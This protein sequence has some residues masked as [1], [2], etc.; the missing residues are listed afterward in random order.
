MAELRPVNRLAALHEVC[1]EN[2]RK[3]RQLIPAL[4]YLSSGTV[5]EF[6]SQPKLRVEVLEKSRY[7]ML[8]E[9]NYCFAG[10]SPVVLEPALEVRVYF[11]ARMAEVLRDQERIPPRYPSRE[12]HTL[13]RKWELNYFF[14]KWLDHCLRRGY[15]L[16]E[17]KRHSEAR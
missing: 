14:H 11:D 16:E 13:K 9:F 3:L 1:E 10:T 8:L 2:Y 6:R 12:Q 4:P 15:F 5:L 7:T 17:V